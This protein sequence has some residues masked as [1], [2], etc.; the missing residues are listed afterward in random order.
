MKIKRILSMTFALVMLLGMAA[1]MSQTAYAE[2]NTTEITPTKTSGTMTITLVIKKEISQTV[3][4]KV[5]NGSWNDGTTTDKTVTLNGYEGDTLTLA[6]GDIPAVGNK[7][8]A[9]YKAGSWDTEPSAS[10]AITGNTTYIYTYAPKDSISAIVT[11]KVANGS[12]DDGTMGDKTVTL[13]GLEGDT[14]KLTADQIPAVGTKPA[15]T[16][17]AGAWDVVPSTETAITAATTYTYTYAAK[18]SI[19]QTVTFKVANGSWDDGNSADITVTLTGL[20]GD[21]LKLTADQIPAVGTKPADTFKAGAWDVVPSTETEITTAATYTYTYAAKDGISQTVTFKVVNGSWDNGNTAD[22]TVTLSGLEGDTLKLAENQIPAVG[23]KPADTFKEGTWDVVPSTETAITAATTYTYTY[24]AKDAISQT[25]TFKVVNGSWD[26]GNSADITV[27]LSGLEGDTLKLAADQIPAV[28]AKP[29]ADFEAGSW[30]VTPSTETAITEATTYTYTYATKDYT[31]A[32]GVID[33]INALP[34]PTDVTTANKDAI[35]AARAAYDALPEDQ[36]AKVEA[37]TLKKLA[38]AEAALK[39]IADAGKLYYTVSGDG[40]DHV[41]ESG[42]DATFTVK[43]SVADDTTYSRFSSIQVD[44]A[45]VEASNY[46]KSEGSVIIK[47][48]AAYLD[49]LSVGSHILKV[50]FTDGSVE[51]PFTVSEVSVPVIVD[52]TSFEDVAVPSKTFTFKKVWEGGSEKSIDFTLYKLGDTVYHHGF[53]KKI[54]SKT[55][56]QYNAWFSEAVACY[57]IEEPVEGYKTQC[58]IYCAHYGFRYAGAA[59]A[60]TGSFTRSGV[61]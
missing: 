39:A 12:W 47:L 22:I 10:T 3:T 54:I 14:L 52:P 13:S 33:A 9:N 55:E 32:Q 40:Q 4:F 34:D 30:D 46:D 59:V 35:E 56:W 6:A 2:G 5:V 15:D 53:D 17:K 42:E 58:D 28:G 38:D 48:K 24:A 49:T 8:D 37:D 11:F 25:V 27:T 16:F 61:H 19:S 29:N 41:I 43:R 50:L 44:G 31:A 51:I 21:T 20:E 23:T 60:C 36:K 7:P 18:D 1:G 26:D 57:V 45:D